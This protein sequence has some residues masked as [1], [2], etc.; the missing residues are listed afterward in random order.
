MGS[1]VREGKCAKDQLQGWAKERITSPS[2]CRLR[3]IRFCTIVPFPE[4]RRSWL[5]KAIEE[6]GEDIIG[7]PGKP[8]PEYWLDVCERLG[9]DR[10]FAKNSEPLYGVKFAGRQLRQCRF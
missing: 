10:D 6:E 4:V 2:K 9:L 5:P 8:H 1:A 3:N 7:K